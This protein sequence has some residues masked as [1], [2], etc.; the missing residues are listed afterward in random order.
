MAREIYWARQAQADL[1]AIR[2]FIAR[3]APTT[4]DAYVRRLRSAVDRLKAFPTA[5]SVV[6]E[7]GREDIREVLSGNYRL[8]YR[9]SDYRVDILT[10]YHSARLLDVDDS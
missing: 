1:R 8:I 3:D 2:A 4:A 5:G 10:V 9:L 7:L 6:P